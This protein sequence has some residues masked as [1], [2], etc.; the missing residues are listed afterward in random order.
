MKRL[1]YLGILG[2]ALFELANVW[3][4]MPMP[5]SQRMPSLDLAY[6]LHTCAA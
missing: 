1:F 4:I 5:G 2:L 6:A 3:L